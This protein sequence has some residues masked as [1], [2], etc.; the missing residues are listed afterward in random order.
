MLTTG[1]FNATR[2][3]QKPLLQPSYSFQHVPQAQRDLTDSSL[4]IITNEHREQFQ[5]SM[6]E[7][8]LL[9][10]E[11]IRRRRR[12]QLPNDSQSHSCNSGSKNIPRPRRNGSPRRSKI[13]DVPMDNMMIASSDGTTVTTTCST[14]GS[15]N[16]PLSLE[17]I[18][19][20]IDIDDP[21]FGYLIRTCHAADSRDTWR[22]GMLQGFITVTTF[23]N[24]QKSFRW[25]SLNEAAYYE[26]EDDDDDWTPG[27]PKPPARKRDIDGSLARD[28]QNTVRCG[29]IHMEGIVWPRIAEISLLGGLGCGTTLINLLIEQLETAPPTIMANYDY[30]VLQATDNS[31]PFYES[32]GFIR[33]GAIM[34]DEDVSSEGE[35]ANNPISGENNP[36]T[37]QPDEENPFVTSNVMTHT[38]KNSGETLT[39]I[40][41]KFQVDV[42]DIIFLN[43]HMLGAHVR[44]CDKPRLNTLLLIPDKGHDKVDATTTASQ[45]YVPASEIRW[46]IAKE[47][48][49]PRTIAK[50]YNLST[51]DIVERNKCRLPGLMSSSRL[52][53]GTKIKVSHLD[54]PENLYKPYA[55]WSFP[56]SKYEDPEPSYMMVRKLHRRKVPQQVRTNSAVELRPF[57]AS[58]NV[59]VANNDASMPSLLLPPL[60]PPPS[61]QPSAL[62]CVSTDLGEHVH[63]SYAPLSENDPVIKA[64]LYNKV[65]RLKPGAM[66]EGSNYIYWYVLTFIP[67]LKWCHLAPMIQNGTFG[68]DKPKAYGKVKWR[69][70]DESLGQEVDISSSYCVPVRSR[71]MRKT[72]DADKEEWDI[73]DDGTD[74]TAASRISGIGSNSRRGSNSSMQPQ[75][76]RGTIAVKPSVERSR[77]KPPT[78]LSLVAESPSLLATIPGSGRI[79]TVRIVG[80]LLFH[81]NHV[82]RQNQNVVTD[83]FPQKRGRPMGSKNKPKS[84]DSKCISK[85]IDMKAEQQYGSVGKKRR[86]SIGQF[87]VPASARKA[88]AL[89]T[90]TKVFKPSEVAHQKASPLTT[91]LLPP[92]KRTRTEAS[93]GETTMANDT[94]AIKRSTTKFTQSKSTHSQMQRSRNT[95]SFVSVSRSDERTSTNVP[96][97][98]NEFES[99][100]SSDD[101][102][103]YHVSNSYSSELSSSSSSSS[104]DEFEEE[105]SV[106]L[107]KGKNDSVLPSRRSI[108]HSPVTDGIISNLPSL[109]TRYIRSFAVAQVKDSV[110]EVFPVDPDQNSSIPSILEASGVGTQCSRPSRRNHSVND[111]TTQALLRDSAVENAVPLVK[112]RRSNKNTVKLDDDA[113][114]DQNCCIANNRPKRKAVSMS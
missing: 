74:P 39:R 83:Y 91:S 12:K 32:M 71:S 8:L 35:N 36:I 11:S 77:K 96:S 94:E 14:G 93:N 51:Y 28:L 17:Y 20:R 23:T 109:R 25:D 22:K 4:H 2:N 43:K 85:A 53:E 62:A 67:D 79:T 82:S 59:S 86:P 103:S 63:Q 112:N 46:H 49:T 5:N 42:W 78:S 7:M 110:K 97:S 81:D 87:N 52:K 13:N 88:A 98:S 26:D 61:L 34:L 41:A 16:K 37:D 66:T 106:T 101:G 60:S 33:V 10:K 58:L 29:D 99:L 55:H 48:D 75:R 50:M 68:M 105:A 6:A 92:L 56:D 40:A 84:P 57:L 69:L 104:N 24:W 111:K 108:R 102:S 113:K 72:L 73:I 65:V 27:E 80:K 54:V 38:V 70:V 30:L 21:C 15:G 114:K 19:D 31:I 45:L 95:R 89:R 76:Q 9:C 3:P 107:R 18:A 44:P 47:N 64:S 100:L 1:P 90:T